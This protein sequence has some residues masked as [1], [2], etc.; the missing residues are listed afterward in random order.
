MVEHPA[1]NRRVVGSNP[2]S[3]AITREPAWSG[4]VIDGPRRRKQPGPSCMW[5]TRRS[6]REVAL[7]ELSPTRAHDT[8]NQRLVCDGFRPVRILA[9]FLSGS[10]SESPSRMGLFVLC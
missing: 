1:V 2:T 9:L 6:L 8:G 5:A 4:P 10:P 3:G 7:L